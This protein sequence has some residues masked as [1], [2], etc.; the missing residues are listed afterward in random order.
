MRK[1]ISPTFF[2]TLLL[3]AALATTS[4][5]SFAASR[6]IQHHFYPT[7]MSMNGTKVESTYHIIARDPITG[8][9]TSFVPAL[10]LQHT[11]L[12][13]SI[14]SVWKDKVL[15]LTVPYPMT[16]HPITLSNPMAKNMMIIIENGRFFTYAPMIRYH[17]KGSRKL[18]TYV[19]IWYILQALKSMTG[20]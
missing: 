1:S 14:K 16:Y 3:I 20:G 6:T 19:P 17:E 5:Y 15:E 11:L 13:A 12:Y 10:D 2:S 18:T 8:V 7:E 4:T 9:M